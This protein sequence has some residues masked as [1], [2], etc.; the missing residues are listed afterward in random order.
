MLHNKLHDSVP[1][2]VVALKVRANGGNNSQHCWANNFDSY[3]ARVGSGVQKDATTPY[4][5]A[6]EVHWGKDTTHNTLETIYIMRVRGL[7]NVW[8]AVQMDP[9]CCAT[10]PWSRN[11]RNVGRSCWLKS[12]KLWATTPNK[13]QP[14]VTTCRRMCRRTHSVTSNNVAPVCK[15]LKWSPS[16]KL[17]R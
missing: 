13:T 6:C 11:K 12:F 10:L 17:V 15:G 2:F 5:L 9:S 4:K 16:H 14:D 8:R 7:N 3:C 1:L